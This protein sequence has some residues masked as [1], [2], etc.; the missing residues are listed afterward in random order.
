MTNPGLPQDRRTRDGALAA[1]FT[2]V[3][4]TRSDTGAGASGRLFRAPGRRLCAAP[5]RKGGGLVDVSGRWLVGTKNRHCPPVCLG[6]Q[7]VVPLLAMLL[8]GF[9]VM[10]RASFSVRSRTVW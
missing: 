10:L 3:V 8:F 2:S 6:E 5:L 9:E 7:V 4:F 1:L